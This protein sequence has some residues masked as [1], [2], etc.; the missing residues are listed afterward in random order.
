MLYKGIEYTKACL[1][2]KCVLGCGHPGV[3][4]LQLLPARR[5]TQLPLVSGSVDPGSTVARCQASRDRLQ[6]T[7]MVSAA[8]SSIN[9]CKGSSPAAPPPG[10]SP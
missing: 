10:A 5:P 8:L 9:D 4:G 6:Q 2:Q 7:P 3:R 1:L